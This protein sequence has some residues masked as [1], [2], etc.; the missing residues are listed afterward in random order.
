MRDMEIRHVCDRC[1]KEISMHNCRT[2]FLRIHTDRVTTA[3]ILV[4]GSYLLCGKCADDFTDNF[5]NQPLP[6][7]RYNNTNDH[8]GWTS[9][10]NERR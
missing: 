5:I 8:G 3:G 2:A 9:T 10:D 7:M 4:M 6:V 1:K